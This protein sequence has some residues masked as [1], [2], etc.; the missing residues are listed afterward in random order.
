MCRKKIVTLLLFLVFALFAACVSPTADDNYS[1]EPDT[2]P[3][4]EQN[5]SLSLPQES[6]SSEPETHELEL[7]WATPPLNIRHA[8]QF[9]VGTPFM[10][11]FETVHAATF[12]QWESEFPATLVIWS[13]EPLYN[14]SFVSVDH[15]AICC[16]YVREVLLT[17]D[18]LYPSDAVALTVAF[19]HYLFP[20]AGIVF[21]DASG[22]RHR[23]YLRQ[24]MMGECGPGYYLVRTNNLIDHREN[25]L[26]LEIIS[27]PE[28]FTYD[29]SGTHNDIVIITN[30]PF[31]P[32]RDVW[33]ATQIWRDI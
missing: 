30:C 27:I 5:E 19:S 32:S 1:Y 23:M 4:F 17:V 11:Q 22:V 26:D 8:D 18:K 14:F 31:V 21:T 15:N 20:R 12:L 7:P 16:A 24:D 28:V 25:W 6:E 33:G 2:A 9:G 13:D 3:T 10:Y 29:K